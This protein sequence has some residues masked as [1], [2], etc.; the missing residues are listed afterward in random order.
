M[1][2]SSLSSTTAAA[3][4]PSGND[5][6]AAATS[7]PE[8][9]RDVMAEVATPVSVVTSM[10]AGAPHGTTV[11]AFASLSMNP[12]MI[13]VSLDRSSNLLA[14]V[15]TSG[16]F[17]VNVLGHAQAGIA[18]AFARKGGAEKFAGVEWAAEA[19]LP[20][21]AGA[22]GW[23]VCDVAALVEGGDH[24]VVTGHVVVA[25]KQPGDPLTYHRRTFGT[26][27]ALEDAG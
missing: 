11:S 21:L 13:L 5:V 17:G 10:V 15:R 8:R 20:R 22:L 14:V 9:L 1:A 3:S 23:L 24:V 25:E 7:G 16:R 6:P 26:H 12:P 18:R 19:G 2:S 27:A 4:A